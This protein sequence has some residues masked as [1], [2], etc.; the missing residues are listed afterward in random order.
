MFV[1]VPKPFQPRGL[2]RSIY[3]EQGTDQKV[4]TPQKPA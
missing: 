3:F 4:G 1:L 2:A